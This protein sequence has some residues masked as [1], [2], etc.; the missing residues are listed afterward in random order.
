MN[1]KRPTVWVLKEQ[2]RAG[3]NGPAPMDYTA[4]Y[5]FGDIKFITE[6]DPPLHG[7]STVLVEWHKAVACFLD[8]FDET[9][10]FIIP[11]GSPFGIFLFGRVLGEDI[12]NHEY[13]QPPKILI[14]RRE[15]NRYVPTTI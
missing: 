2:M 3:P 13:K 7:K 10:D 4:A 15:Q 8:E 9:R 1:D 12:A 5:E 11:T 6:F 14:W